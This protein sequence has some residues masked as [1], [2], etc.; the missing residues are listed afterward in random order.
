MGEKHQLYGEEGKEGGARSGDPR[1]A[2]VQR[3][4]VVYA[5]RRSNP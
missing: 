1:G 4:V 3:P 5:A 2:A